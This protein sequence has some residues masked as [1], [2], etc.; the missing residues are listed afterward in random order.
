VAQVVEAQAPQT[1]TLERSLVAPA[2]RRPVE[3]ASAGP[4][5][6]LVLVAG[7]GAPLAEARERRRDSGAMGTD[8]ARP[9]FGVVSAS[10]V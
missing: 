2:Q 3:V 7:S 10:C 6:D 5:E 4:E 1:G 9:D 8:R